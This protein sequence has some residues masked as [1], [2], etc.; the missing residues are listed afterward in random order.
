MHGVNIQGKSCTLI[1]LTKQNPLNFF[2]FFIGRRY[3][4]EAASSLKIVDDFL[5]TRERRALDSQIGTFNLKELPINRELCDTPVKSR[6][7][8]AS[9]GGGSS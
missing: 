7:A 8:A 3:P 6:T 4:E 5:A 1:C 9:G 2:F